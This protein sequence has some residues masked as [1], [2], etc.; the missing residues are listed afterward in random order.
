MNTWSE[1]LFH[2]YTSL[3]PPERL[4]K[5]IQWLTPQNEVA[6]RKIMKQFFDK[7][8]M[9]NQ[10]R[11]LLLGINPGR[12]GAGMTGINF[13][14]PKQLLENCG[15]KHSFKGSELSA[16]FVYK[17]I[18]AYGGPGVFYKNFFV[19]SVCPLGF[20]QRGK[21][22]NYYDDKKLLNV[23]EPFILSSITR[24]LSFNADRDLCICIGGKNFS[25]LSTLNEKHK[26]F[27][28]IITVPHPRFIMQ[29][30]RKSLENY[31]TLYLEALKRKQ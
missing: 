26:W 9:D 1:N 6:V 21:N 18:D 30:K 27:K 10:K 24:L 29:Y 23:I 3:T 15:I 22:L 20:I 7:Y 12:F 19:G 5:E 31:V 17:M 8:Y 2:F 28:H 4:P 14:A 25:Y 11:K 13:T 16:E